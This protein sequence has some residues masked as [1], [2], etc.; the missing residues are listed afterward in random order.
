MKMQVVIPMSG[1]GERFRRAGFNT[2]KP[3]IPVDG[4]SII[5]HVVRNFPPDSDFVFICNED[6]IAEPAFR[7][8]ETLRRIAPRG[9][10]VGVAPHK[11]GPV[12]AVLS[13]K[14]QIRIDGPTIVNY[15]D[16]GWL[17]DW[18]DFSRAVTSKGVAGAVVTYT[19]FHPH[20]RHSTNYAYVRTEQGFVTAIQEKQPFTANPMR[21]NASSGTYFFASGGLMLEAFEHQVRTHLSTKGEFYVSLAYRYLLDHGRRVVNY[22]IP[23][24]MQWG[25][26]S[27][28]SEYL[29]WSAKF[30]SLHHSSPADANLPGDV[31]LPMAGRGARFL[32]AGWVT[33]K[34]LIDVSA[35][36][37]AAHAVG[38]AHR[39]AGVV[40]V[41]RS[42]HADLVTG[43]RE[44]I[45]PQVGWLS[46]LE[47]DRVT[48]GQAATSLLGIKALS[49]ALDDRD[50]SESHDRPVTVVPSD[51]AVVVAPDLVRRQ[52]DADDWDLI[53]WTSD[54]TVDALRNP[55]QYGWVEHSAEGMLVDV[56]VKKRPETPSACSVVIG[57]FTF[58]S[59]KVGI[60]IIE[61]LLSEGQRINGEFYLDTAA[62]LALRLGLRVKS[63]PVDHFFCWGTPDELLAF[64]YWQRCF[65]RW[66]D[67]PYSVDNDRMIPAGR[68]YAALSTASDHQAAS[69]PAGR[70]APGDG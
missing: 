21:E 9:R 27:D 30:R 8:E 70:C 4:R 36:P 59:R 67:H 22:S 3:L 63:L 14:D 19:G 48:E 26:P 57:C 31:V 69:V 39:N 47:V 51:G 37:M 28:L 5:E 50:V 16:F 25:T 35:R 34:P 49:R 65:N 40:I 66:D 45:A 61:R 2:P 6:H 12:N 24:F 60:Q 10:I 58:R 13:A 32:Q 43:L 7:M 55:E 15:C 18:E 29:A 17:W 52:F 41:M 38:I 20:M 53:V 62:V 54:D 44:E 68:G 42:E 11:L 1:F 56:H 64:Q 23:H 33:P 46:V